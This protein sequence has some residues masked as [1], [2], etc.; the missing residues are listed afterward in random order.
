[1]EVSDRRGVLLSGYETVSVGKYATTLTNASTEA[2]GDPPYVAN[3]RFVRSGD[4]I[5]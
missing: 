5:G 4:L 1:V 2:S 3:Y